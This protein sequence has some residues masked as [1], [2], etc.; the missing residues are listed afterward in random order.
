MIEPG[1]RILVVEDEMMV[2]MLLEDMLGELGCIV[3]GPAP[4]VRHA[5]EL[6]VAEAID[7]AI[8]DVNVAGEKVFAVADAL[9]ARGIPFLFATGYGSAGL[10]EEYR[11]RPTLQKPFA[12]DELERA[13]AQHLS[14]AKPD[15]PPAAS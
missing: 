1:L 11:D 10:L 14:R 13:V 5:L 6:A 8:L 7:G 3:V 15:T 4:R 12:Q 9:A 2:A